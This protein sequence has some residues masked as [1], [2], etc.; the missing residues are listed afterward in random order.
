M[1]YLCCLIS[2]ITFT[3]F[4]KTF[5]K[6]CNARFNYCI[7]YP[8]FL[9]P[10]PES[11]NG[12]GRVFKNKE[13]ENVL[14]VFGRI[15]QDEDGKRISLKKQFD[16]DIAVLKSALSD[17]TYKKF[18]SDYYVIRGFKYTKAF[19]RKVIVKPDKICI[20]I[21]ECDDG[22]TKIFDKVSTEIF[23]DFR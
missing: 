4:E 19:Y 17:V 21:I 12:D 14:T 16:Q 10:Q 1:K 20:A 2:I 22:E 9:N 8:K 11:E 13:G 15:N 6:Y 18:Y 5:P 3:S 7:S 23:K